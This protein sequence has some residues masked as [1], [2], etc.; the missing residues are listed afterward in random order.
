[1]TKHTHVHQTKSSVLNA[2]SDKCPCGSQLAY[3]DCCE[4]AHNNH[5]A[6][7]TPA[8]LMRSRYCAHVLKLIDYVVDT[9]HPSCNAEQQRD[10]IAQS[11]E[12]HW[13]KLDVADVEEGSHPDEGFVTF[14][15]YFEDEKQ[16]YC[17]G[18]RSR[19]V[20]ENNLWYYIDG[21]FLE[22][23]LPEF[24]P[25]PAPPANA[26]VQSSKIGRNDPCVCGS[27]KKYKKCCG[28]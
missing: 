18:E 8:Q 24:D 13:I 21:E 7:Q 19:F 12:S 23:A 2:T 15:A 27:G 25:A 28:K 11:V 3:H 9:Y 20:R 22:K 6:V 5:G 4:I 1:M 10:S 16:L 26:P 14:Y 17:L